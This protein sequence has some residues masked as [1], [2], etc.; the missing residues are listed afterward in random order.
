MTDCIFC[1][2]VNGELPA[3]K[4]YENERLLAF[5]DIK[6]VAPV[7]ILV[8]PKEHKQSLNDLGAEDSELMGEMLLLI[9]TL[10]QEQ[11]VAESGYRVVTNIGKD[12]AQ[13]VKHLHFHLLGGRQMNAR[14]E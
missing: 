14:V 5:R 10:A 12:G 3:D 13:V 1:K 9:K 2:I 7:H 4:V 6:P 8:V 11:G